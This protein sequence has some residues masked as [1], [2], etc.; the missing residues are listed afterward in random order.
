ML[1]AAPHLSM[2]CLEVLV[3]LDKSEIPRQYV[4]SAAELAEAPQ[5][6]QF[7]NFDSV[8]SCQAVGDSWARRVSE[9]AI[10]CHR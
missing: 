9:L 4:W 1:Y 6:L 3:H 2:A 10:A 5:F 7:E 8:T